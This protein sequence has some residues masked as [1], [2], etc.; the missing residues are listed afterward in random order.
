MEEEEEN[1]KLDQE[2]KVWKNG[3]EGMKVG[4]EG[5]KEERGND[6]KERGGE[7]N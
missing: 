2:R 4:T 7:G 5:R 6:K 1:N 3:N